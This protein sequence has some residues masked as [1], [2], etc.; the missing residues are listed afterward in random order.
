MYERIRIYWVARLPA[1]R[2]YTLRGFG[3]DK[4]VRTGPAG[5]RVIILVRNY[6]EKHDWLVIMPICDLPFDLTTSLGGLSDCHL[7]LCL[8]VLW[9]GGCAV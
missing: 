5:N 8:P 3:F 6:G 4:T 1:D 7:V 2:I 9:R